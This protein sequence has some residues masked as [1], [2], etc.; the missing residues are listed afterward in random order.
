MEDIDSGYEDAYIVANEYREERVFED[1]LCDPMIEEF[2]P[3]PRRTRP[4]KRC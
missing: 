4:T 1:E 2:F 3:L